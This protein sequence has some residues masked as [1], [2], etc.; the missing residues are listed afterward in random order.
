MEKSAHSWG[1]GRES[2]L[3]IYR[4]IRK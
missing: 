4:L 2:T 3:S 1:N